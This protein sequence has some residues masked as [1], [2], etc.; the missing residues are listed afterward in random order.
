MRKSKVLAGLRAGRAVFCLKNTFS[1]PD[2][3]EMMGYLGIDAAWIC[4]EHIGIDSETLRNIIRAGRASDIDV[5]VRRAYN[6]YDS[7]IQV[8]EMGAAGLMIPHCRDAAMVRDIVRDV[9]FP[10]L[11]RRGVDGVGGDSFYGSIRGVEYTA[12]ANAETFL[13]VQV[14]DAEAVEHIE[15]IAEVDGVDIIFIG[16]LDLSYSLGVPGQLKHSRIAEVIG[17]TIEACRRN[18]KYC[19]T[20][21]LDEAYTA[22]LLDKGVRFITGG[23]DFGV[24]RNGFAGM[25]ANFDELCS[26]HVPD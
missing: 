9:K 8:L 22:E 24:L 25:K 20:P 23:G 19:G 13:M 5:M 11:G 14:E 21:G 18:G 7:L 1:S 10:P 17:R 16:P 2:I 26:V 6:G 3:V 12:A 4:N 15:A